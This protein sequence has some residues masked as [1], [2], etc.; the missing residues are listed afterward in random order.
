MLAFARAAKGADQAAPAVGFEARSY[1]QPA[2]VS[3]SLAA[4]AA[5]REAER[6]LVVRVSEPASEVKATGRA[7]ILRNT[8]TSKGASVAMSHTVDA[9]GNRVSEVVVQYSLQQSCSEVKDISIVLYWAAKQKGHELQESDADRTQRLART[10]PRR[11]RERRIRALVRPG[12]SIRDA[13]AILAQ[14]KRDKW[15]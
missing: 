15:P 12:A 4:Y 6:Q 9:Q 10:A 8:L 14:P 5:K 7:E 13:Q 11:P 1:H 3:L 2:Q